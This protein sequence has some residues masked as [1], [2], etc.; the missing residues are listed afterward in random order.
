[1]SAKF[2]HAIMLCHSV[3]FCILPSL[4]LYDSDVANENFASVNPSSKVLSSGSL[5]KFPMSVTLF[6]PCKVLIL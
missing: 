5:P 6:S 2:R 1:M 4:S 3:R